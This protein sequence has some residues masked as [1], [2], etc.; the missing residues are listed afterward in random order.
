MLWLKLACLTCHFLGIMLEEKM[1]R[2]M[3]VLVS[4]RG[5]FRVGVGVLMIWRLDL[6]ICS[7]NARDCLVDLVLPHIGWCI[8]KSPPMITLSVGN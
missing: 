3:A 5:S 6:L 7:T 1:E 2:S 4:F 8:L